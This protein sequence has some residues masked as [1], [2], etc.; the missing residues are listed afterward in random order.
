MECVDD[1]SLAEIRLDSGA[2]RHFQVDH[3]AVHEGINALDQAGV[4]DLGLAHFHGDGRDFEV[5]EGGF[6]GAG[7]AGVDLEG[8]GLEQ[9]GEPLNVG[10][11]KISVA[12]ERGVAAGRR[13][14]CARLVVVLEEKGEERTKIEPDIY[15]G[16]VAPDIVPDVVCEELWSAST[17]C[18]GGA[19]KD[20]IDVCEEATCSRGEVVALVEI[21]GHGVHGRYGDD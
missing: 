10:Q 16:T 19:G 14:V 17:F 11:S 6:D 9:L 3:D 13:G 15:L 1:V 8:V 5:D 7:L 4:P 20:A 18:S 12:P 21:N 2:R